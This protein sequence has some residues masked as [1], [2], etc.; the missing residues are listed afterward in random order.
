[1]DNKKKYLYETHTH[2]AESSPCGQ[3]TSK[4]IAEIYSDSGYSGLI[5][6]D[7][8]SKGGC[9]AKNGDWQNT[10]DNF[11]RGFEALRE[12]GKKKGLHVLYGMEIS[13]VD[14]RCDLLVYG[15]EPDFLRKT[16]EI[17]FYKQ[18]DLFDLVK[19][20]GGIMISAHPYRGYCELPD[21]L[22]LHGVEVFNGNPRH[23]SKNET[24]NEWAQ[25][26]NLIKLAGSDFHQEQDI[27][28]GVYLYNKPDNISGFVEM[29]KNGDYELK[30]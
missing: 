26:N 13:L 16:K 23:D 20:E 3:V 10:A 25:E 11:I 28:S 5:V 12:E 8:V 29:I 9:V 2:T 17:Y 21:P 18:K 22:Y 27:S 1:M 14:V 19:S 6:T 4:R 7:H 30:V 15:L 24:A